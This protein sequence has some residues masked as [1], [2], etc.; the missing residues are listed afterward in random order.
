MKPIF[1]P[2]PLHG[3]SRLGT[4]QARMI[5]HEKG[6]RRGALAGFLVSSFVAHGVAYA[7]LSSLPQEPRGPHR[8]DE[9]E[10]ALF[11]PEAPQAIAIPAAPAPEPVA[12]PKPRL[13]PKVIAP[14]APA[15]PA[16]AHEEPPAEQASTSEQ[17]GPAPL[18]L[19][20]SSE[21]G[22][23]VAGRVG[24]GTSNGIGHGNGTGGAAVT[25]T[26]DLR[27]IAAEW[28]RKVNLAISTRALRDYPRSALRAQLQGS[29][30]LA[31][32]VDTHGRLSAVELKQSSGHSLLDE[33]ALAA[34]RALVE[35]PAPP[36]ALHS[37]L[38]PIRIPIN[39]RVQ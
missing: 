21:Q 14:K 17:P 4:V 34:A 10:F 20:V 28:V 33:A 13:E 26:V 3:E 8:L 9:V 36:E 29:V 22:L 15:V 19:G 32:Q 6:M 5:P 16:E 38:R 7:A 11:E 2:L 12:P 35:L 37:Q 24:S 31:V 39:Y 25:R 27:A 1:A 30:L 23:A 18:D